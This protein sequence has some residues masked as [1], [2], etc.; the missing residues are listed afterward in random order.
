MASTKKMVLQAGDRVAVIGGGA[1]GSFFVSSL[2]KYARER[3]IDNLE[4]KIFDPGFSIE[5]KKAVSL[6]PETI[7]QK[8]CNLCAGVISETLIDELRKDGIFIPEKVIQ[9]RIDGYHFDTDA[10]SIILKNPGTTIYAVYRGTPRGSHDEALVSFDQFMLN[11]VCRNEEVEYISDF[12]SAIALGTQ[13]HRPLVYHGE[14]IYEAD[15][16]V[17]ACGINSRLTEVFREL[18]FGYMRPKTLN[19]RQSEIP[20]PEDYIKE[21]YKD[22]IYLLPNVHIP[23]IKIVALTPKKEFLTL[24]VIGAKIGERVQEE[25]VNKVWDYLQKMNFLPK[26]W[27]KAEEYCHCHPRLPVT[28]ASK[29]FTDRLVIIGDAAACRYLKNGLY[30]AKMTADAAAKTA[31]HH[32]ISEKDFLRYYYPTCKSIDRDNFYGKLLFKIN[33]Y[34]ITPAKWIQKAHLDILKEEEGGA[35]ATKLHW[36]LWNMFTGNEDY[37]KVFST[38]VDPRFQIPL[39]Y[40]TLKYILKR[41]YGG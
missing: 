6:T 4:I 14:D 5:K 11:S 15:L 16:V 21:T 32:G 19:A 39:Q 2:L 18:G 28:L 30:S 38:L 3:G 36:I 20:F 27:K 29:P 26:D 7:A 12:V 1:S 8:K 24:T 41:Q 33:D 34:L 31:I 40:M 13:D 9:R 23:G 22:M 25:K 10:G 17:G 35:I 37:H